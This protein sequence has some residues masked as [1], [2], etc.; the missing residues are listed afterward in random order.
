MRP[1][2]CLLLSVLTL[3][4]ARPALAR[5]GDPAAI[6]S[7]KT[8]ATAATYGKLPMSF[9]ENAGQA[10]PAVRFLS[11]G[12]GYSLFLTPA[13]AVVS[14]RKSA[15]RREPASRER[16]PRSR[17]QTI[18]ET[19]AAVV[20][21]AFAGA[22]PDPQ[23]T[24]EDPLPGSSN[25]FIGS[26]QRR[27]R[28]GVPTCSRVRYRGI[29][30]GV[31]AVYYGRERRLEYD[32]VV[33]PG[34]D[35]RQI[36][37]A[38]A[39]ARPLRLDRHGNLVLGTP[40]GDLVQH[41]PIAYQE[42]R[43]QR[44]MVQAGY[45]ITGRNEARFQVG[46]YDRTLPLVLDPTLAYSTYLGGSNS[47]GGFG[48]A[49][50]FGYGIAVDGAG[51]AYVTGYT[52]STNFPGA[53]GS[54]IQP[55]INGISNDAFVTKINAAGTAIVY[56][57]YL[58]GSDDDQG[59]AIAVDGAGNAYVFGDTASTDFPG[60]GGSP[61]QATF[62]G[63]GEDA[64]VTK[65]NA[66]GNAIVYSTYLGGSGNEEGGGIAVDHAGNAYVTGLTESATFPGVTGGSIQP[67]NAGH[68]ADAFVTKINA[69]GTAI[70][71][72]TF[73]GG[74]GQEFG[75]AIA[76]DGTGNAYVTGQTESTNFPG[77]QAS[78]IQS[79]YGGS[80]DAYVTKINAAGT[81]IVYS[82]YLG[83]SGADRGSGIAV[84]AAGNAYV[85]GSTSSTNFRGTGPGSIQAANG[86]ALDGFVAKLN[87]G[88][89]AIVYSTYLGG[90]DIDQGSGIAVDAAGNAYVA[91]STKSTNFPGAGGSSIQPAFGGFFD[92][93][94]TKINAAGS[95]LVYSTY[96]G[97]TDDD[98]ATAIA[99]DS[100]G[101]A[102]VTG[103]TNSTGFPGTGSSS[104]QPVFGGG[105]DAFVTK[106]A[107]SA[108][109]TCAPSATTLCLNGSRF[110]VTAR[111]DAGGGNSGTAQAVQLT[112][113]TGYL[114]FFNSANVEAI[115]KVLNGCALG[116]HYWV[117]AGGLTNV[118]VVMTVTDTVSHA[119]KTYTNPPN[120]E[121]QPIQD[122]SAFASCPKASTASSAEVEE[123]VEQE[124]R[125]MSAL[126]ALGAAASGP[127][128]I[129]EGVTVAGAC[130]GGPTALC[131]N[132]GR[133]EV[134]A[135][136]DDGRGN[137]GAA[138]VV[139]LTPDTGYLWFFASTNVEAVVKVLDACP[140]SGHWVFAAGLTNVNV[141][142]TVTDTGTGAFKTYT[143][144]PNTTF[145]PIQDTN[146]FTMCP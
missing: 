100:S 10:D 37:L 102:Y 86:G 34:A 76:V 133:F 54:P 92:G 4:G 80:G 107:D 42:I 64:F 109:T 56:S 131:L 16:A 120:T 28:T 135:H 59:N 51:N 21:L 146:D 89:T 1:A 95:A 93:F 49:G 87:A 90:S 44:R 71:Y 124:A 101:N 113:D 132:N 75:L 15:L 55:A 26:D 98:S 112:P 134:T 52:H 103:Y 50:D 88:G 66:A 24:G 85:T 126:V 7:T 111:F 68:V 8:A 65:I 97:G 19:D 122:T 25:Y 91:G 130:Q 60:T 128:A 20:R 137:S 79:V 53:S 140:L 143:N 46:P 115:V 39:G 31:D 63:G 14:L 108:P 72:S 78:P 2:A 32:L 47:A 3:E 73:L 33:S 105:Y 9:E 23:V 141:A 58:G 30:P 17:R 27:W 138:Q 106:I 96:L 104:I 136:F 36:R 57:T 117:F 114:W 123:A 22:R 12:P 61:I 139:Q 142:L 62:G 110:Q 127:P 144:P 41:R 81:A 38:F 13:E 125:S 29:Y 84:D 69:A 145:Q 67:V 94:V 43:G 129:A 18:P 45:R 6:A 119:V 11:R 77:T 40:L 5:S 121:F 83:G 48:S 35:P 116:G 74:N 70:V 99:A 82:T 118:N